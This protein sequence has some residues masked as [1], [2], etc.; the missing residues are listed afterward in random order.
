MSGKS[1]WALRRK[2]TG[3][4]E[5]T[6]YKSEAAAKAKADQMGMFDVV[7]LFSA[8]PVREEGGV[9]EL[10]RLLSDA[11]CYGCSRRYGDTSSSALRDAR[12]CVSCKAARAALQA[13][14]KGGA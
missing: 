14:Q 3:T 4:F 1:F 7:P 11:I 9:V 8:A 5:P 12:G 6:L 2:R 10:R 13:E